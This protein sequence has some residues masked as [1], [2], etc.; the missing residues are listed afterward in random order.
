VQYFTIHDDA[1]FTVTLG[2][3]TTALP[4]ARP[5]FDELLE[6]WRWD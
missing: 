4:D 1:V 2:A 6:S 5:L 3:H